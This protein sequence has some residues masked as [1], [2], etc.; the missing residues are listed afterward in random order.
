METEMEM[1]MERTRRRKSNW[2]ET[3][4]WPWRC[5][6]ALA[7]NWQ[8]ATKWS[9]CRASTESGMK[10]VL[11]Y[12]QKEK[13]SEGGDGSI[14]GVSG[15]ICFD[16]VIWLSFGL[17]RGQPINFHALLR[18]LHRESPLKWKEM[19]EGDLFVYLVGLN[20]SGCRECLCCL[21]KLWRRGLSLHSF[22]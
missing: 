1:E 18:C 2:N 8:L 21:T 19:A 11:R 9:T 10:K 5:C 3:T 4:A 14:V 13:K 20:S 15:D 22:K 6:L 7:A 12:G 16:V 17:V